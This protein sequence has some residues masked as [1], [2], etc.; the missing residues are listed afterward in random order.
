M[1]ISLHSARPHTRWRFT[2]IFGLTGAVIVSIIVLA[3]VWP[4]A[5]ATPRNLPVGI[6]GPTAH[7]DQ[8]KLAFAEQDPS[9][10]TLVAID[11]RASA[12]N[13]ISQRH[14]YGA[15]LLGDSPE[16]LTSSAASTISNQALRGVAT[17]L[18]AKI[19]AGVEASLIGQLQK[20]GTTAAGLTEKVAA[21]QQALATGNTS[22]LPAGGPPTGAPSG[23]V[24]QSAAGAP[25]TVTVTDVVALASADNTGAGLTAA[26]FPIVLGGMLGGVLVSLLVVGV[27]RRL[28]ALF[29][30]GAAAGTLGSLVLQ[31]WF[32]ILQRDWLINAAALGLAM[33]A[34]A[35]LVVAFNSLLGPRGI[36]VGAVLSTLIGNPISGATL[37]YQ[38]LASPWGEIGQYLVPG[39]ASNLIRS[40]SYFPNADAAPQWITLGAWTLGGVLLITL[41]HFRSAAPIKLPAAELEPQRT[42]ATA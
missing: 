5:T 29:I 23:S 17:A 16:V 14:L 25:P 39:A 36:A 21:L 13:E 4:A 27:F 22:G 24:A 42:P 41:G 40:L 6:A 20:A 18:Q 15:I 3:F 33:A 34:T 38:F 35:T 2:L 1:S 10:L 28:F 30:F 32:Q 26:S 8:L 11:S 7:V 31:T 37:P 12:V 9:P 19:N